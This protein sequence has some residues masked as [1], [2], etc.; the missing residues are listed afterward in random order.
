MKGILQ[1]FPEILKWSYDPPSGSLPAAVRW[2][3]R[4]VSPNPHA[5][6]AA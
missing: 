1:R 4:A 2:R 5:L 3:S 6:R